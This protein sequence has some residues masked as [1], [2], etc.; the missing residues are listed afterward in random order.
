MEDTESVL[1]V[2]G[3]YVRYPG[4]RAHDPM[5]D[6]ERI[7]EQVPQVTGKGVTEPTIRWRILKGGGET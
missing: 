1:R 5:E 2:L 7:L 4:Y 3:R 6:T